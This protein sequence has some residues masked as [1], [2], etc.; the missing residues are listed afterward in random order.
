MDHRILDVVDLEPP[1]FDIVRV[2]HVEL[3]CGDLEA[4]RRFYV[5]LL[6]MVES[7]ASRDA[8]YLRGYEDSTHHCLVLRRGQRDLVRR[9]AFRVRTPSDLEAIAA[10]YRQRGCPTEWASDDVAGIGTALHVIDPLGCPIGFF[11]EIKP[12]ERLLQRYDLH[13]GAG[14]LRIDHVNLHLADVP[15]GYELYRRLGFGVSEY[16]VT[17][18]PSEQMWAAWLHRKPSVH[19]VALT[20]GDGPRLH[21]LAFLVTDPAAILHACDVIAAAGS[22]AALERG[23][24]RHGISNAFFLYLRDPGGHRVELYVGDYWTGDPGHE[25]L[26]WSLGDPRRQT[27]WGT[28]APRSWFEESSSFAGADGAPVAVQPERI[29]DRPEMVIT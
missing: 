9:I 11:H 6:G 13:R 1:P 12:A 27:L 8:V 23:P 21:H 18:P 16:T 7:A 20:S 25:P 26:R 5:D 10:W 15:A 2:A 28:P 24:G 4:S 19:D 14:I 29:E 17:D 3:E 22:G